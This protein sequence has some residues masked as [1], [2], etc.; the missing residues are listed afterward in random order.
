[1]LD[2]SLSMAALLFA[3]TG[4]VLE[5]LHNFDAFVAIFSRDVG[6][7]RQFDRL[8]GLGFDESV[9]LPNAGD[10]VWTGGVA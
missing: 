4:D 6:L 5:T 10:G 9:A 2:A 3:D 8:V 7:R 1:M